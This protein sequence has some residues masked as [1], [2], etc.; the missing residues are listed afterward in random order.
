MVS[1]D[2]AQLTRLAGGALSYLPAVWLL[3]AVAVALY[4]LVP[5]AKPVAWGVFAGCVGM[6]ILGRLLELPQRLRNV[7]PF[8]HVPRL[9]QADWRLAPLA[10][11]VGASAVVAAAGVAGLRR[12]DLR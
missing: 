8:E 11:L 5:K 4:G 9:P 2:S 10:V 7:S 6:G 1:G 3:G 12:R